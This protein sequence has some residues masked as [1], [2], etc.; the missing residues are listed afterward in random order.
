MIVIL[1]NVKNVRT[2]GSARGSNLENPNLLL[3]LL[4][5]KKQLKGKDTQLGT[6][7]IDK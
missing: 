1:Q 4:N 5:C 2:L 6:E 7:K 3:P